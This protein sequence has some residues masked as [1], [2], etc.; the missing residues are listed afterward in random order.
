MKSKI[1]IRVFIYTISV[2]IL[3]CI[4]GLMSANMHLLSLKSAKLNTEQDFANAFKTL[5]AIKRDTFA[6]RPLL[7][8]QKK[9]R[10]ELSIIDK[11]IEN[12]EDIKALFGYDKETTIMMVLQDNAEL[13]PSG[14][15]WGAYGILKVKN[16]KVS[17]FNTYDTYYADEI[18][19]GKFSP[20]SEISSI[21]DDEWRFWNANWSPDYKKSVEQ[22]LF[23]Y[24]QVKP[25]EKIDAVL[26]PNLDYMLSLL[27]ISGAIQLPDHTF[28]LTRENFIDK[29]VYEPSS[30]AV[31]ESL[32]KSNTIVNP[33]EK[34]RIIAGIGTKIIEQIA[35]NGDIVRLANTTIDALE[36][37]D[38]EIYFSSGKLQGLAESLGWAGRVSGKNNFA[39]VVDANMGSKLDLYMDKNIEIRSLGNRKY[40]IELRYKN[41]VSLSK[42]K[43]QFV[44][45][46]DYVRIF[47]PKGVELLEQSG[48][49]ISQNVKSDVP[50]G[51][52]YLSTML[53][54]NPDQ[55]ESA[56]FTWQLPAGMP[57]QKPNII[58]QSG[59]HAM[60]H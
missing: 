55:T 26:G 31:Y 47:L 39:M 59:Q 3:I 60:I 51:L 58:T 46:R 45:Y 4:I 30:P 33:D 44:V 9:L 40:K 16:G 15:I 53:I 6:A 43:Q 32:K 54:I 2:Y 22:G 37:K 52:D 7:L 12:Q 11:L 21:V 36:N 28:Q 8:T 23:F 56:S 25:S 48:G 29:M 38:L 50:T 20:P 13:R 35:K 24:S 49:E 19:R 27:K 57:D 41:N 17:S 5:G 42:V 1:I 18:N 14:G 10:V 34:N